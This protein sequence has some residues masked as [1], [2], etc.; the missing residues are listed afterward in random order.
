MGY[1]YLQEKYEEFREVKPSVTIGKD[2][3]GTT[4]VMQLE[5][6]YRAILEGKEPLV[7]GLEG[8]KTLEIVKAIY[9]SAKYRKRIYFP[10]TDEKLSAEEMRKLLFYPTK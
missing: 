5:D 1:S 3:W 6:F 10:F 2:Y 9:L 7:T 8:R 4:H